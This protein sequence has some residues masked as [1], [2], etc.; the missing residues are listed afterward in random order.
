MDACVD[1]VVAEAAAAVA[2]D[3]AA[4]C[5]VVADAASTNK[6]HL[7]TSVFDDI[8]CEPEDVC[9]VLQI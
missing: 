6:S 1:A 5:D 8:G 7:A 2:D 3:A 4:V 9:D